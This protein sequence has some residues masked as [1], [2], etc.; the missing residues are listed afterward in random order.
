MLIIV[1][2]TIVIVA[3]CI[4]PTVRWDKV[5]FISIFVKLNVYQIFTVDASVCTEPIAWNQLDDSPDE[6]TDEYGYWFDHIQWYSKYLL[7]KY[8]RSNHLA[9]V[10]GEY[11]FETSMSFEEIIEEL[12][13]V[14]SEKSILS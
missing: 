13:F 4:V 5:P 6:W 2:I 1:M 14:S 9:I 8:M 12:N 10:P 11:V 3:V 7:K